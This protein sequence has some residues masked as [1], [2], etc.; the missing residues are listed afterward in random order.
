MVDLIT[1]VTI[2]RDSDADGNAESGD[3]LVGGANVQ[4]A[5]ARD[6]ASFNF[7]GTT[8]S[9][10]IAKF[11]LQ[12]ARNNT[13]Y[14]ATVTSVTHSNSTYTYNDLLDVGNEVT[15]TIQP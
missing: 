14:T 8:N 10:G 13:P 7:A 5:L 12:R 2:R 6:G 15:H 3:V 9:E 1:T 4:M 11:T